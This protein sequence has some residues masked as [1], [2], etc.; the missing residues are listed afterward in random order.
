M[1]CVQLVVCLTDN[2]RQDPECVLAL[3]CQIAEKFN[4]ALRSLDGR[5]RHI[6][7]FKT[8]RMRVFHIILQHLKVNLRLTDN[9]LFADLALAGL[10]ALATWPSSVSRLET[11]GSTSLR[12]INASMTQNDGVSSSISGVT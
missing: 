9:A 4:V 11:T 6:K 5:K 8:C 12:E 1:P 10:A 7:H 2:L 3:L